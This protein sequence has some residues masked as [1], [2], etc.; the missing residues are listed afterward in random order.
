[1]GSTA[2]AALTAA[3]SGPGGELPA[4]PRPVFTPPKVTAPWSLRRAAQ[5][6]ARRGATTDST[7]HRRGPVRGTN[8]RRPAQRGEAGDSRSVPGGRWRR[9][10]G[11]WPPA[12][13]GGRAGS[14]SDSLGEASEG[15]RRLGTAQSQHVS[16]TATMRIA[17]VPGHV[18]GRLL[19]L[20]STS[21][22]R[23]SMTN[24]VDRLFAEVDRQLTEARAAADGLVVTPVSSAGVR[25][26]RWGR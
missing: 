5:G 20:G 21:V 16:L 26:R 4:A 22:L 14:N 18:V 9:R 19:P 13:G 8:S 17:D 12:S 23:S 7:D 25:S 2:P 11:R 3:S 6:E 1:M 10:G 24:K 15:R